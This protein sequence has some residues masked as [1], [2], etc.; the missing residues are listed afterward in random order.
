[1]PVPAP[2]TTPGAPR[3]APSISD[4]ASMETTQNGGDAARV[5]GAGDAAPM[6]GD[7]SGLPLVSFK[8]FACHT[9]EK[10]LVHIGSR[11][12]ARAAGGHWIDWLSVHDVIDNFRRPAYATTHKVDQPPSRFREA[13]KSVVSMEKKE[14]LALHFTSRTG[15]NSLVLVSDTLA[16]KLMNGYGVSDAVIEGFL[17]VARPGAVEA[18]NT[19]AR[20]GGRVGDEVLDGMEEDDEGMD[21]SPDG[22]RPDDPAAGAPVAARTPRPLPRHAKTTTKRARASPAAPER[23]GQSPA[24]RSPATARARV[25]RSPLQARIVNVD[26]ALPRLAPARDAWG[27]PRVRFAVPAPLRAL[28]EAA[29]DARRTATPAP[30]AA[31]PR[32]T[33]TRAGTTPHQ[34]GDDLLLPPDARR[35]G[36][37]ADAEIRALD[38]DGDEALGC[39]RLRELVRESD[40]RAVA[41]RNMA[42][43]LG[44]AS[45]AATKVVRSKVAKA[46]ADAP[47]AHRSAL[48]DLVTMRATSETATLLVGKVT[49]RLKTLTP[50][51][52]LQRPPPGL[53]REGLRGRRRAR[54][55][56]A[57]HLGAY[58]AAH[59][60]LGTL[61]VVGQRVEP[62]DDSPELAAL[63]DEKKL[64][65]LESLLTE[66]ALWPVLIMLLER[67]DRGAHIMDLLASRRLKAKRGSLITAFEAWRQYGCITRNMADALAERTDESFAMVMGANPRARVVPRAV[68]S[69]AYEKLHAEEFTT[70]MQSEDA[71]ALSSDPTR[72]TCA[73]RRDLRVVLD[74]DFN[75]DGRS[76]LWDVLWSKR[77]PNGLPAIIPN[78]TCLAWDG[79]QCR[80]VSRNRTVASH[81][82]MMPSERRAT[83]GAPRDPTLTSIVARPETSRIDAW[84]PYASRGT[85]EHEEVL[86]LAPHRYMRS[87]AVARDNKGTTFL[88]LA[89]GKA[90]LAICTRHGYVLGQ[91]LDD[92]ARAALKC[93][94]DPSSP[95]V[96]SIW[97]QINA[98]IPVEWGGGGGIA[99]PLRR[100]GVTATVLTTLEFLPCDFRAVAEGTNALGFSSDYDNPHTATSRARA[101]HWSNGAGLL[102][103]AV[104]DF[105]YDS[106]LDCVDIKSS[107]PLQHVCHWAY[108]TRFF[109][110]AS[111][112]RRERSIRPKISRIDFDV[113][114]RENSEVWP[115]RPRPVVDFHA[116]AR[117]V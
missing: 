109:G 57:R 80:P 96:P 115:R 73:L 18:E 103:Y 104:C 34:P 26:G 75:G 97:G 98:L 24:V 55:D 117:R 89:L 70:A 56:L 25:G 108:A 47:A 59:H 68:E 95:A 50:S 1:M 21:Q 2:L 110:S 71:F 84:E 14:V 9:K 107:T 67:T 45:S 74:D 102:T 66:N 10:E 13:L 99:V 93:H 32:V 79:A 12:C 31:A 114:E 77:Y 8:D 20:L 101:L 63:A 60:G 19:A 90:E 85:D 91:L 5:A 39:E 52:L 41:L 40:D 6:D 83:L 4:E 65:A 30:R 105:D 23:A 64:D 58:V 42:T 33:G 7:E 88:L 113:T 54:E 111:R 37:G 16:R 100:P 46:V 38:L 82:F 3:G 44:E 35:R 116:G 76:L 61:A 94:G 69:R 27:S 43:V 36:D 17:R 62:A 81:R 28:A 49:D 87:W 11:G 106:V 48:F 29:E 78:P 86:T 15:K 51:V 92:D 112:A 22:A 53:G 72:Q